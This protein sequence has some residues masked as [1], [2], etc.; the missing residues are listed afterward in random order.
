MASAYMLKGARERL[1]EDQ[2]ARAWVAVTFLVAM[3][4]LLVTDAWACAVCV[5]WAEG[6]G[7]HAGFYVSALLLSVLPFA[8]VAVIG[9]WLRA[10]FKRRESP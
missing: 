2:M 4:G 1:T 5:G 9:A 6:Q 10:S 3:V 8:L 7:L